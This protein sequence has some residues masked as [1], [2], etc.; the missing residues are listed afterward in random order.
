MQLDPTPDE[1]LDRL[2][3]DWSILQLKRGHRFSTDD[4]VCAW[5]ATLAVPNAR[6]LLDLGCG[7]GSVG[8]S[9]LYRLPSD[10]VL[11]GIEAQEISIAL[12]RRTVA[13]NGLSDRVR[14]VHGDLRDPDVLGPDLVGGGFD[15]VTGSPP[16]IPLGKGHVSPVPQRAG[17]RME[18]RGSVYDY[19]RA[20]RRYLAPGGRFCFVMAAAD[21]RTE[22]APVQ[23]G[24]RVVERWDYVFARGRDPLV[25]TL[26]CAR[27]EDEAPDRIEGRLVIRGDDGEWTPEYLAFR[28]EMSSG[29]PR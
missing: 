15:L 3:G 2:V 6:R 20:A 28:E 24:L 4:L 8:L 19:C 1:S 9:A 10:A 11:V 29:V 14:L 22:D 21:P 26:V 16:Y 23:A 17:A 7:I 13:R 12:A 5:R 27:A 18:L 25:A